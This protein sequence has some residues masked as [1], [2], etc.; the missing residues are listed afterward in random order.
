MGGA[1]ID[2]LAPFTESICTYDAFVE[3]I[4]NESRIYTFYNADGMGII[5]P[6]PHAL[7]DVRTTIIP[8]EMKK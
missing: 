7:G 2:G 6:V 5:Y 3:G 1:W 8:Y 4:K